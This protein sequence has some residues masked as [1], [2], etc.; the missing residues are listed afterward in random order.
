VASIPTSGNQEDFVS[1]G[2]T[3]ALKLS[4]VVRLTR[5]LISIEAL[6]TTRALMIRKATTAGGILDR[7]YSTLLERC[8]LSLEDQE[9]TPLIVKAEECIAAGVLAS[10]QRESVSKNHTLLLN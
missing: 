5:L 7:A 3:A 2:M 4:E 9:L 8:G 10:L 1:M 6:T